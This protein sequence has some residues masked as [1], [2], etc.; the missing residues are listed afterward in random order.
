LHSTSTINWVLGKTTYCPPG[1]IPEGA[2]PKIKAAA[3]E[4]GEAPSSEPKADMFDLTDSQQ[5]KPM[6]DCVRERLEFM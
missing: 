4:E 5:G 3:G 6:P 1:Y 2:L